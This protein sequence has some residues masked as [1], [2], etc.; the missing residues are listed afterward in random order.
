LSDRVTSPIPATFQISFSTLLREDLNSANAASDATSAILSDLADASMLEA[1]IQRWLQTGQDWTMPLI[2][3]LRAVTAIEVSALTYIIALAQQRLDHRLPLALRLP[4][5]PAV[6]SFLR[7]WR[8]QG[9]VE[10]AVGR[11]LG[12]L[13]HPDD[14]ESFIED[15]QPPANGSLPPSPWGDLVQALEA[16]HFFAYRIYTNLTSP[17][18]ALMIQD[19]CKHW[20]GPLILRA[21]IRHLRSP[22]AAGDVSRVLVYEALAN[23]HQ[24]PQAET[25][26]LSS[27]FNLKPRSSS[28][29]TP[30]LSICVWD[31]GSGVIT[32]LKSCIARGLS[33]RPAG[34]SHLPDEAFDVTL[35]NPDDESQHPREPL[36]ASSTPDETSPDWMLLLAS[37]FPGITRKNEWSAPPIPHYGEWDGESSETKSISGMGLY[38]LL[39]TVVD[40]FKG[41]VELRSDTY[42]LNIDRASKALH[43]VPA[44]KYHARIHRFPSHYPS[45]RGNMLTIH[46][47]LN[48]PAG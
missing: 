48:R 23:A 5:D 7:A 41:V 37:F 20:S 1:S 14:R 24:H 3:D 6:K 12:T 42:L 2:L 15:S 10:A 39:R 30:R 33:I 22:Q 32:T 21:L 16:D 44:I 40:A 38:T 31:D 19:A 43:G 9:A 28:S 29:G 45:F 26:C 13:I 27:Q 8:F 35:T 46:L 17:Y 18:D 11:P 4:R 36:L 25:V 47:P 34:H